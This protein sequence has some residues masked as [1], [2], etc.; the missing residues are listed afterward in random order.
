V[1]IQKLKTPFC[2]FLALVALT[3]IALG[4][5]SLVTEIY[6]KSRLYTVD[7]APASRIAIVFGAGLQRDGTPTAILKDRVATAVDLYFAGKV[8]KILMSG[9]NRFLYY[10]EPGAMMA[11]AVKLGVP[12]KELFWI[13]LE[14]ALM[15]PVIEPSTSLGF[16]SSAGYPRLPFTARPFYLQPNWG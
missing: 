4:L 12:Q 13:M 1:K 11:Y 3:I 7:N 14:G 5:P 9:D 8:Q 6:S 16:R 10:N 2:I 15:T